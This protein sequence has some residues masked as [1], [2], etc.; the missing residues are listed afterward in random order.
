MQELQPAIPLLED[1]I[2]ASLNFHTQQS[3]AQALQ[4]LKQ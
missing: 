4:R 3:A 2:G 1:L